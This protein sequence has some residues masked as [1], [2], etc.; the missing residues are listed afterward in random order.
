MKIPLPKVEDFETRKQWEEAAWREFVAW[1]VKSDP[2][3]VRILLDSI[4]S[5]SERCRIVKRAIAVDR[6]HDGASYSAIGRELS[7]TPQT[8]SAIKKGL[9]SHTYKSNWERAES[10]KRAR[11]FAWRKKHLERPEPKRYRRTKYGKLRIW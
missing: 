4:M 2:K 6:I 3:L 8:I 7:L 10:Q 5:P 9:A 11:D 1:C